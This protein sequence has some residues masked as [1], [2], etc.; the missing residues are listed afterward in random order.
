MA[1]VQISRIQHRRGKATTGTGF[2]QLASGEIGWAVDTQELYI[3]NGSVSEGSPAVGN[4][5]ILTQHDLT[6]NNNLL[7]QLQHI[8]RVND[9]SI[10][11]GLSVTAPVTRLLQEKLDDYVNATDFG[12][13]ADGVVDDTVP[14]QRAVNQ[15]FLNPGHYAYLDTAPG[16]SSRVILELSPG[17][18]KT[19]GT[20]FLPSYTNIVGAGR[21]KTIIQYTPPTLTGTITATSATIVMSSATTNLIGNVITGT[22]IP[23]N[24]T[25]ISVVVGVSVTISSAAT[26]TG[27]R[28]LTFNGPVFKFVN[29]TST[30]TVPAFFNGTTYPGISYST[31]PR[32]PKL[33]GFTAKSGSASQSVLVLDSVREGMFDIA[34]RG[35]WNSTSPNT[36]SRGLEMTSFG[37]SLTENNIFTNLVVEN[38]TYSVYSK[39]NIRNNTFLDGYI[40]NASYGFNLGKDSSG[41]TGATED[42]G[43]IETYISNVKFSSVKKQAIYI[44]Y[45]IKNT[46]V[47]PKL[48]N[49]GNDS[50]GANAPLYP[51]IYI[52]NHSNSV[53][54][55]ISDRPV[56]FG[57][58]GAGT[59]TAGVNY[60]TY[61]PEF[62]GRGIISFD[63]T[64]TNSLNIINFESL[65]L[66]LPVSMDA[67]GTPER[68]ITYNVKYTFRSGNNN[69]TRS[70]TMFITVDIASGLYQMSDDYNFAGNDSLNYSTK[71]DFRLKL[72]TQTGVVYTGA[73]GTAPYSIG[74]YYLNVLAGDTN[75][76]FYYTY[77]QQ[78]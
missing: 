41:S 31:Q 46:I 22:D 17:I 3:G 45:G 20:I 51:Q 76:V 5:K 71:L 18:I 8:Y 66:R 47:N 14:L 10:S 23:I 57:D 58:P 72:L 60:Q 40:S 70:G 48:T 62:A 74:I 50:G 43:A 2:P 6:S 28:S 25:V 36:G 1:V 7:Q 34:M 38:C 65:A 4:T 16:T 54:N 52:N 69:F 78:S 35:N 49:V 37:A 77:T 21:N 30:I 44:G 53:T 33:A 32:F 39:K 11:T 29:D 75:N 67:T 24:A 55:I 68:S 13:R 9:S 27:S 56:L 42:L 63:R 12:V 26:G 59:S 73:G 15:L 19:T 64:Q 61:Y